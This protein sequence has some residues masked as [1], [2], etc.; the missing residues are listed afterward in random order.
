MKKYGRLPL[1]ALITAVLS[2][3]LLLAGCRGENREEAAESRSGSPAPEEET[4]GADRPLSC[5]IVRGD[6]S[7]KAVTDAAVALRK[8]LQEAGLEADIKTDW[9]KRGE[10]ISRFPNEILIGPTNR[11]ESE[12]LY[13]KLNGAEVPYDYLITVGTVNRIAA[14][15]DTIGEAAAVF[16]RE[17]AAWVKGEEQY[18]V[19]DME[20]VHQFPG[21]GMTLFGLDLS[22]WAIVYPEE[23]T[24]E[25][26]ADMEALADWFYRASGVRVPASTERGGFPHAILVGAASPLTPKSRDLSYLVRWDGE[27]L[28]IGG[29]S[30]WADCRALYRELIYGAL[31]SDYDLTVPE[32]PP[33]SVALQD[34]EEGDP[35][36]NRF[37]SVSGWCTSG[38]TRV[39]SA[40][41]RRRASPAATPT[42]CSGRSRRSDP[43]T[44]A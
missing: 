34:T 1:A 29:S 15:D 20:K 3:A 40:S 31:G 32:H 43:R 18:E 28:H 11:P 13:E 21:A 27:D 26:R 9:V 12:E 6:A 38:G 24:T 10:E 14:P 39:S 41:G 4:I 5:T 30:F 23:Y 33:V 25:Q 44:R 35:S 42:P 7:D 22:G 2:L 17:Y 16:A 8:L 36:L 37:F 19:K